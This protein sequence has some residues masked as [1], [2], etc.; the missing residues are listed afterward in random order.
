MISMDGKVFLVS[1]RWKHHAEHS[2]YDTLGNF[3]GVPLT[4]DPILKFLLPDPIVWKLQR[5]MRGYDRTSIALELLTLRHMA[6]HKGCLYHLLNG[7]GIYNYL[8]T[9]NGWRE[10]RLVVT[11]HKPPHAFNEYIRDLELLKKLSAVIVMGRNQLPLFNGL[12]PPE[13][14]YFIPHPIDTEY[15]TPPEDD[16]TR[17]EN[18]CLF[19]GAHLRDYETLR[20][21]IES[22]WILAP[23]IKFALVIHPQKLDELKGVVGN[24]Q[25]LCNIDEPSLLDLYRKAAILVMPLIDTTANNAVLEAMACGLPMIVTDIGAIR[26]YVNDDFAQFVSLFDHQ[27]MLHGILEILSSRT[28]RQQM[29]KAARDYSLYFDNFVIARQMQEFYTHILENA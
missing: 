1:R 28:R 24:Y 5:E 4:S 17:D 8:G 25:I 26:D 11:Y 19:V 10:H 29:G 2:G 9:F 18:L 14:L 13:R 16:Q 27:E 12:L 20:F 23:H 15:F 7:E 22:A 21:V 3:I 6:T